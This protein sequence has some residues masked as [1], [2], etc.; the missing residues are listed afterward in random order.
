M[1][2]IQTVN[3]PIDSASLGTTLMHEH[4]F[5]L[6]TEIEENFPDAWG[7]EERRITDAVNRLDE[8]KSRGVDSL[9]DL[10]VI[11]LGRYIP[12]I[13]RIAKRTKL[14][15]LVATGVYT[16]ND[17]P[18]YFHFQGPGTI[19][20]GP[21]LMADMFVKDIEQ[22]IADTGVRAAMLKCATD[23]PGITPGVERVLRA[24]AQAHRRT[25]API[26]THTHAG[27]RRGLEQQKI[28]REE[29]VDLSRAVIGHCGDTTDLGYLEEIVSNG[30]YIGMDRFGIDSILSFEERV[31]TVVRMCERGH[32]SK[33]VLSH[34]AACFF[35]WFPEAAIAAALPRWHY[36]H[37]HNDV[38]P[39]LKKA[40]VTDGQI[41]TMLV[42]NPRTIFERQGGY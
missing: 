8:L 11:G 41:K 29:G 17:I 12:R 10:T 6:S 39:A 23:E 7:D 33:M 4:V 24:V 25:G 38:V 3:G 13:Q 2:K 31:S 42:D 28:F 34:D 26:S 21:E 32:A 16:Y 35:D 20:G 37:I 36:L 40:G 5:V 1:Q 18:M 19:F 14:N 15:I 30:S 22:G 27:T 9:V